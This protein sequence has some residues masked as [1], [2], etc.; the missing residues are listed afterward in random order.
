MVAWWVEG[1]YL[2]CH[3]SE[4]TLDKRGVEIENSSE[5]EQDLFSR[6]LKLVAPSCSSKL[7]RRMQLGVQAKVHALPNTFW[8]MAFL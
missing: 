1:T 6:S 4:A 7:Y 3:L 5:D 2:L 8:M